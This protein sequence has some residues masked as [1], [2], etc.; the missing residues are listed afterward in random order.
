MTADPLAARFAEIWAQAD[1]L[2]ESEL[3]RRIDEVAATSADDPRSL[4][5]RGGARDSTGDPE[6]AVGFYRQALDDG[7]ADPERSQ[8][9]IQLASTLRNLDRHDEAL[10]LIRGHF[11]GHDDHPLAAS[12]SAF[13]ALILATS[14]RDREAVVELLRTLVP[15]L[16]RYQRSLNAYTDALE[17]DEQ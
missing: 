16:P 10:A 8:V 13:V 11:E 1:T 2:D 17:R 7:L 6:G 14:G 3:V 4:A 5:E 15:T 9:V 12:A